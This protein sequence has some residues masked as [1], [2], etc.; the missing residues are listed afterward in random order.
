M[1][2]ESAVKAVG[3]LVLVAFLAL[4]AEGFAF[5]LGK[6]RPAVFDHR[7]AYFAKV[8]AKSYEAFVAGS[9][10]PVL[11]WHPLPNTKRTNQACYGA[12]E[13]TRDANAAR[14]TG[15]GEP[16]PV[17]VLTV[18][19]S[20]T[21]GDEVNDLE[22]YSARL[23]HHS[24]L[25]VANHG[26]GGYGPVQSL[27]QLKLKA[28]VYPELRTVVFGVMHEN[29]RRMANAFRPVYIRKAS[30]L[31]GFKPY[32]KDGEL[33]PVMNTPQPRSYEAML[34]LA[35]EA[36]DSDYWAKPRFRFPYSIAA[37]KAL[38]S[39]RTYDQIELPWAAPTETL[40][41]RTLR[42]D[43]LREGLFQVMEE[44]ARFAASRD[45]HLV[46]ALIPQNAETRSA[47]AIIAPALA[48]RLEKHG[49]VVVDIGAQDLD[50][51]AYARKG[52]HPSAAGNDMLARAILPAIE[53][54]RPQ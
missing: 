44:A 33:H 11:G 35:D 31:Y 50:W 29:I 51:D 19:D 22:T 46:V 16:A 54:G 37:A 15:N 8:D 27:H 21:H 30:I 25:P 52:C 41:T 1:K 20:F 48:Q 47:G 38:L 9:Y 5:L 17:Q 7:D 10:H 14:L 53:A 13:V 45:L 49:A 28:D 6:L 32:W 40:T 12:W 18:G 34:E 39:R 2:R 24:G 36:F 43:E 42:D 26:V 3:V 4:S 23:Q